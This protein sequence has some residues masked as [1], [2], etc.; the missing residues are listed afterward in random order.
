MPTIVPLPFDPRIISLSVER[1]A[2]RAPGMHL[3]TILRDRLATAGIKRAG[4]KAMTAGEQHLT[5]EKGFLWERAVY[6]YLQSPEA[7]QQEFDFWIENHL[8]VLA[9]DAIRAGNGALVRPGECQMDGIWMTPDAANLKL[10]HIEEWKATCIKS[11]GFKIPDRKPEWLWQCAAYARYYHMTRAVIRVL[12][13]GQ[14]PPV[15]NQF[16]IDWTQ[17]E[18]ETNWQQI[19]QHYEFMK[20]R[21]KNASL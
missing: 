3:G 5:F 1:D 21:D 9:D 7:I 14:V 15:V 8:A 17:D 12:H 2:Q 10:W 20:S 19:L 4:S 6:E 18:I 16:V 13:H 11:F